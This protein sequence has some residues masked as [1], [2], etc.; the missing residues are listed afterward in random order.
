MRPDGGPDVE[1]FRQ[2]THGPLSLDDL[3]DIE[4]IDDVSRSHR[5]AC[6]ANAEAAPAPTGKGRRR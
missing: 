5:D 4:E 3:C 2:L 6:Q 1:M